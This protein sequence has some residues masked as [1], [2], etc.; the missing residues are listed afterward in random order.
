MSA[1]LCASQYMESAFPDSA[2]QIR[3][4]YAAMA[5]VQNWE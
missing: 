1:M 5:K 3:E 2:D 4:V